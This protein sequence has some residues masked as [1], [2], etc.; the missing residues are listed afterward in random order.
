MEAS[1]NA[2]KPI[3]Y[4]RLKRINTEKVIYQSHFKKFVNNFKIKCSGF[5]KKWWKEGP[6]NYNEQLDTGEKFLIVSNFVNCAFSKCTSLLIY[7]FE[8]SYLQWYRKG[9]YK[10]KVQ[11][12]E[13]ALIRRKLDLQEIEDKEFEIAF[14]DY[15]NQETLYRYYRI[16]QVICVFLTIF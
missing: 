5:A 14:E 10:L 8:A 6:R 4:R 11:Q 2:F 3:Y 15:K 1:L 16:Y 7:S 12:N 9:F 13:Y